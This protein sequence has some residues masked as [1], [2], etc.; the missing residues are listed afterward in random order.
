MRSKKREKRKS[1]NRHGRPTMC[2]E[3]SHMF[4]FQSTTLQM[5]PW[6]PRGR[7]TWA[8]SECE[9]WEPNQICSSSQFFLFP[10][11]A[12]FVTW[13]T[14]LFLWLTESPDSSQH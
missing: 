11:C 14:H 3:M 4:T 9:G 1:S 13:F 5:G 12:L 6:R 10:T 2:P 7:E 8:F